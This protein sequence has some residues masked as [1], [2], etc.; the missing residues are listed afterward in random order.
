M[1]QY[2]G[3][4]VGMSSRP[5]APASKHAV[6]CA[7]LLIT[8]LLAGLRAG[9]SGLKLESM[10]AVQAASD[11]VLNVKDF[12][13]TGNG[14]KDDTSAFAEALN[15][16]AENGGGTLLIPSGTY[17]VAD[18][19]VGSGTLIKGTGTPLPVLVKRQE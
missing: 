11:L 15:K 2:S 8:S 4:R 14:N 3:D 17:V 6:L 1:I 7:S 12:Q 18:L 13:A 10:L 5:T 19:H 16:L 9:T